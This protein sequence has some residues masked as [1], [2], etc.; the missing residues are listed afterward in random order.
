M[1]L[2]QI[3]NAVLTAARTE[4]GHIDKVAQKAAE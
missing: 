2:E 3:N 4:A 1:P